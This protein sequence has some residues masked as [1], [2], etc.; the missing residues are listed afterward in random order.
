MSSF[1]HPLGGDG[2]IRGENFR[3]ENPSVW[4]IPMFSQIFPMINMGRLCAKF[5]EN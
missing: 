3:I 4:Q 2:A 1:W 5:I